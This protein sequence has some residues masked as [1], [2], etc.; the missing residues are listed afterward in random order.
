MQLAVRLVGQGRRQLAAPLAQHDAHRAP[1]LGYD[2]AMEQPAA[3]GPRDQ[4]G[5]TGL[6][7]FE[8]STRAEEWLDAEP[9]EDEDAVSEDEDFPSGDERA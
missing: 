8:Q 2:P 5:R 7:E 1:I 6:V 4:A 3:L 9:V